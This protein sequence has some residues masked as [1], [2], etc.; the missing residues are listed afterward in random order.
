MSRAATSEDAKL[1]LQLYEMRREPRLRE[2]RRWFRNQPLYRTLDEWRA[3]CP[4]GSDADDYFRMVTTYWEMVASFL[5]SG[6]LHKDL[7]FQSGTELLFCWERL[8]DILPGLRELNR[9]PGQYR[10]LEK[11]APEFVEYLDSL[12]PDVYAAFSKRVRRE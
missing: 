1:I 6:V 5:T 7:Y 11:I 4:L 2:A 9:N 8:R 3:A 10:N 12:G